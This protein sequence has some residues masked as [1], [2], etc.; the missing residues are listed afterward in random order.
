[1]RHSARLAVVGI[2][3]LGA[4]P[5]ACTVF[6]ALGHSGPRAVT[7]VYAGD[8]VLSVNQP[9]P[10]VVTVLAQGVPLPG[11]RLR[12]EIVPDSTRVTLNI[13]GDSL[14]PCRAGQASLLIRLLHSS[15]AGTEM[16]DTAVGLRVTGGAPPSARCP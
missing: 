2:V 5:A 13:A 12:L 4:V 6:D 9:V 7:L 8:S 14:I 15:A 10:V 16:P 3:V 11:Q 1:M